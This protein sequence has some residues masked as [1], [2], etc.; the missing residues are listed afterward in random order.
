MQANAMVSRTP[1]PV[2][3]GDGQDRK[4]KRSKAEVGRHLGADVGN[5]LLR[6]DNLT[7]ALS[8]CAE[9]KVEEQASH[10]MAMRIVSFPGIELNLDCNTPN[11]LGGNLDQQL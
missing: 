5:T 10:G 3:T 4:G 9:D 2:S 6:R 1:T 7:E 8:R 11:Y